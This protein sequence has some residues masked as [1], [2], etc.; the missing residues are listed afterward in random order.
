MNTYK[1]NG[2]VVELN[3]GEGIKGDRIEAWDKDLMVSDLVGS[4]VSNDN[5][6]FR[7]E[8]TE[9]HFKEL[10]FDRRPDLFFK[11]YRK[12]QMIQNT[13]NSIFWNVEREDV[14]I[15][16]QVPGK[17]GSGDGT[18][19]TN[20]VFS[21][22]ETASRSI[23]QATYTPRQAPKQE[24]LFA[25]R[26]LEKG[27]LVTYLA[28][29]GK[30]LADLENYYKK[31]PTA[32]SSGKKIADHLNAIEIIKQ[33]ISSDS[34][35]DLL[36][37]GRSL[38]E[39]DYNIIY[40][41]SEQLIRL[42]KK[43]LSA[44]ALA[45]QYRQIK[46]FKANMEIEPV[47]YLHLERMSFL[48][49]G[50]EDGE[51]VHSVPLAPGE[52]VNIKHRIWTHTSEEFER[53]V[54]DYMENF[55][56]EGVSE[57]MELAESFSSQSQ[58]SAAFNTG[59]TVS[60]SYGGVTISATAGYN[61]SESAGKSEQVS[62]NQNMDLTRKASS[63]VKKEF[64]ISFRIASARETE[65]ET[66]Q[67]FKNPYSDR[68]TRVDY[69][70]LIRK[71]KINLYRYGIRLTW[72]TVI[73]EPSEGL[74]V[75]LQKIARLR[76]ELEEGFELSHGPEDINIEDP[77]AENYY[78]KLAAQYGVAITEHPPMIT[79]RYVTMMEGDFMDEFDD[80]KKSRQ[81]SIQAEISEDYVVHKTN[82]AEIIIECTPNAN[83]DNDADGFDTN[84][85]W[86]ITLHDN[87]EGKK[88]LF[89]WNNRHGGSISDAHTKPPI[90]YLEWINKSGLFILKLEHYNIAL[91]HITVTVYEELRD[92]HKRKW[93][94]KIWNQLYEGAQLRYLEQ[95]QMLKEKLS[96]LEEEL[97]SQDALTLRKKERE[98]VMRGVL[99]VLG[100]APG[101]AENRNPWIIQFLHHAIEWENMLYFLYPYFWTDP[102]KTI[103]PD[104]AISDD[105]NPYWEFKK[106]LDHPDSTHRTFLKAGAA[107]VVLTIRPGYENTFLAFVNK[108][109]IDQLPPAPYLE[110]GKEFE[111]Y[112]KTN[113]TGIP[114]ANPIGNYRP[115]LTSRQKST[116]KRM[117]LLIRLLDV[118]Y[119]K[120]KRYP[121]SAD[122]EDLT[123][124]QDVFPFKDPWGFDY[125][126]RCPGN[127]GEYDLASL[128]AGHA[129]GGSGINEDITSADEGKLKDYPEQ[130]TAWED[131]QALAQ[132]LEE[133]YHIHGSYPSTQEGLNALK[134][135]IPLK[136]SWGNE[137]S[138]TCP[139]NF[140]EY[141]LVSFGANREQGG[142]GDNADITNWA[143]ASL[144]GEWF[145][146]TPTSALDIKFDQPIPRS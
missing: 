103:G 47:G 91:A 62:R 119:A 11:V 85:N 40:D 95:R 109:D 74:L 56:E 30:E 33:N 6:V 87:T 96:R 36:K 63:R 29:N 88:G 39:K 123:S 145:E 126:Y 1:I 50:I 134:E 34:L 129:E 79:K 31:L 58:H 66:V 26:G 100:Y 55:S 57:K 132:L 3:S 107:R 84:T 65:D 64:K 15:T 83:W 108:V 124:L 22:S 98:E 118:F 127:Q 49:W 35:P 141:D 121:S 2:K 136:D 43:K 135:L 32:D 48:P 41:I 13:I 81:I 89:W 77:A 86:S 144:I 42:R 19:G 102:Q 90:P 18:D 5:G 142:E 9:E 69:Y 106:D 23:L 46:A 137:Y 38:I 80:L 67:R 78:T 146:Y 16:L 4:A 138:Y 120:N 125:V 52:E 113:Y 130:I 24:K 27:T 140:G 73:P 71:W 72:N 14:E 68:A 44:A 111:T 101:E 94:Q 115:Q 28:P 75:K 8:F 20:R 21:G 54:T 37:M 12:G 25:F 70:Q 131:I 122:G 51:L 92:E 99:N 139:G 76:R 117:Q 7:I 82:G 143:E 59:A 45:L 60:G 105:E 112:A 53:I 116:W 110:I 97:G 133:Y 17:V 93:Q 114:P 104:P 61:A 128:G 10:F